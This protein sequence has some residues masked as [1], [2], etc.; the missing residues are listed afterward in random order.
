MISGRTAVNGSD[1]YIGNSSNSPCRLAR[2]DQIPAGY[3]HPTT[4]QCNYSYKHPSTIQCNASTEINSLK[5]SVSNG[6][7]LIA[8]AITGKGVSTASN[9]TFQTMANNISSLPSPEFETLFFSGQWVYGAN[10]LNSNINTPIPLP[11][12]F[13]FQAEDSSICYMYVRDTQILYTW[14]FDDTAHWSAGALEAKIEKKT[15]QFV[16]HY[17]PTQWLES[18]HLIVNPVNKTWYLNDTCT[19]LLAIY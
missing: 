3:V 6:K 16:L 14:K 18:S 15:E 4:K 2:L 13:T 8:S 12:A 10:E 17:V 5:S 1:F 19:I 7:S 9:A 11:R